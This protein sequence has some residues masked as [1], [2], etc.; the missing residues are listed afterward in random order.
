MNKKHPSDPFLRVIAIFKLM[1]SLVFAGAGLGLLH[2]LNRDVESRL[3]RLAAAL[4]VDPDSHLAKWCLQEASHLTN[5]KLVSL[6]AVCFFYAILFSIEGTGLYLKKRWAEYFVVI[7]TASLLPLEGYEI[8][9]RVTAVK[10]LLTLGN[11]MILGY[12]VYIIRRKN[13]D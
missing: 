6:S 10:I 1:K 11:L 2:F 5:L 4:H 8:W 12:L 7:M 13:E 3:Q 9:H